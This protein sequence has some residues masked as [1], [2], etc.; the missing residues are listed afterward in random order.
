MSEPTNA[1]AVVDRGESL[2]LSPVMNLEVAK[3][4]L[5]EFQEF[6]KDYLKEG[7]D[8]GTIPGTPKPTLL[9]PGADKLCEL[10]GLADDYEILD[11]VEDFDRGLFDYTIKCVLTSRRSGALVATGMGSCNSYESKY[12]WRE[13]KRVCPVCGKDAIIKGKKEYDRTGGEGGWLCF[14][15]KGGCGAKFADNDETIVKQEIGRVENDNIADLKNTFLKMAKKRAK[16]DG[17][18]SATRSSGIFG[19]DMEDI[20]DAVGLGSSMENG[21]SERSGVKI[22]QRRSQERQNAP[23]SARKPAQEAAAGGGMMKTITEPQRKRLY[24]IVNARGLS[25]EQAKEIMARFGF[26]S[27]RDV[28]Q[29]KYEAIVD[30]V[31][32]EFKFHQRTQAEALGPE[33]IDDGDAPTAEQVGFEG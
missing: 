30:A 26:E 32:P 4:R 33:Y 2:T 8:Y 20:K 5:A 3:A 6:V 29:D 24:A 19:Q 17:T 28:T 16:I 10:Y 1:L 7:E 25:G 12:R 11:K 21:H 31:D 9:K 22:P 14:T 27:S 15:K 23:A 18:L 13:G